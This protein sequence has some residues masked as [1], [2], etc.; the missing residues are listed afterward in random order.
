MRR[1]RRMARFAYRAVVFTVIAL[2][3][4]IIGILFKHKDATTTAPG[5]TASA[6]S[7]LAVSTTEASGDRVRT[8][9]EASTSW[10]EAPAVPSVEVRLVAS[11]L[12]VHLC[13]RVTMVLGC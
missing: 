13:G 1:E 7:A 5:A 6:T 9:T 8:V 11:T 4:V 3:V 2:V 12:E 10:T